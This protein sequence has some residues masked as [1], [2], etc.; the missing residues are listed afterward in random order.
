MAAAKPSQLTVSRLQGHVELSESGGG[1][2]SPLSPNARVSERARVRTDDGASAV[3]SADDGLQ[4]E[5]SPESQVELVSAQQKDTMVV[6]ER[7]RL[8]ARVA[9]RA[10]ALRVGVDGSDALVKTN[11]ASF[12]VLRDDRGQ[13]AVAVTQGDVALSAQ[14]EAVKIGAGEQSVVP[15]K[16]APTAPMR[17]PASLFLKVSHAGP[18]RLNHK[19]TELGG[20]TTPGA[21]VFVNGAPVAVQ[22]D[23]HFVAHVPLKEGSN[24]LNVSVHD[25]LGRSQRQELAPVVV[26]TQPPKLQGKT[27]W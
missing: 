20:E 12:A 21:S 15:L 17:I 16:R 1:G 9:A 4:V 11:D 10:G 22:A 27:I 18:N 2:W 8:F 25:V 3:L 26:D 5:V 14:H 6:V 19:S 7:G 24:S 13:V 23:G